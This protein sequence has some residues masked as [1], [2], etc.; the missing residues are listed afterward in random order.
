MF[1]L[2]ISFHWL[3][4]FF[5][6]SLNLY[7]DM[8]SLQRKLT[9]EYF[10]TKVVFSFMY[11]D[12]LL[13]ISLPPTQMRVRTHARTH[14]NTLSHTYVR[15]WHIIEAG[16]IS[17]PAVESVDDT[18]LFILSSSTLSKIV[19]GT[20]THFGLFHMD[21]S[22]WQSCQMLR[23]C[24]SLDFQGLFLRESRLVADSYGVVKYEHLF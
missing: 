16:I 3:H 7:S 1:I 24:D 5:H 21:T 9:K 6:M 14:T 13:A 2:N 20:L 12:I 15:F 22:W 4:F 23:F 17:L 18:E 10:C 19:L 11:G 8:L